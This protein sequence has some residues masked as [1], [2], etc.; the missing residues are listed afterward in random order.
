MLPIEWPSFQGVFNLFLLRLVWQTL[1]LLGLNLYLGVGV[2]VRSTARVSSITGLH[3][4]RRH[5][6]LE[7]PV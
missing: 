3:P 2:F 1:V 6:L 7:L 5:S 4:G